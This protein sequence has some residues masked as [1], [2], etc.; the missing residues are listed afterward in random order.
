MSSTP[1]PYTT[2]R[3]RFKSL[4]LVLLNLSIKVD[5]NVLIQYMS[6]IGNSNFPHYFLVSNLSYT[7]W[8]FVPDYLPFTADTYTIYILIN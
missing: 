7:K 8:V 2:P 3:S 1:K 6:K 4:N 5:E